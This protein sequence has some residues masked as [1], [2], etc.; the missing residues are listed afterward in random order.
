MNPLLAAD[1]GKPVRDRP[2]RST[3]YGPEYYDDD[4]LA[5]LRDVL[6]K[7]QPFRWYGPGASPPRKVLAF[8]QALA[9]RMQVKYCAWRHLGNRG[10]HRRRWRPSV[11]ARAMR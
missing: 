2:L 1:G 3:Y 8:E 11:L 6:A 9:T 5:E 10:T 7:R 4:E